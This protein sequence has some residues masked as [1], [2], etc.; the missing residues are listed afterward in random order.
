M[1]KMKNLINELMSS[2]K[3]LKQPIF[4]VLLQCVEFSVKNY[5][6]IQRQKILFLLLRI[7]GGE[8]AINISKHSQSNCPLMSILIN[9]VHFN[10]ILPQ[11]ISH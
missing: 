3:D 5:T 10:E 7:N 1:T 6:K 4:I 8:A 11:I 9:F 2:S